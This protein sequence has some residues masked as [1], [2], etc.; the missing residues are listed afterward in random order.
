[1]SGLAHPDS[2]CMGDNSDSCDESEDLDGSLP[3]YTGH[4]TTPGSLPV[5]TGPSRPWWS[6]ALH[7]AFDVVNPAEWSSASHSVVNPGA[8]PDEESD[9]EGGSGSSVSTDSTVIIDDAI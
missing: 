3:V 7:S 4:W 2:A 8:G 6:S 1:M 5:Y 9:S